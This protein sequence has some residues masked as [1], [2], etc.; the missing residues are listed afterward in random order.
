L[1]SFAKWCEEGHGAR[2]RRSLWHYQASDLLGAFIFL[3]GLALVAANL[4][5]LLPTIGLL[6]PLYTQIGEE[7]AL[8][9][10]RFG[11]EYRDYMERVPRFIPKFRN[12][13]PAQ[14]SQDE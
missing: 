11:D 7:E 14:K 3:I 13:F 12:H 10:D 4:L 9:I 1:G 6:A 5:I 8:L 2:N